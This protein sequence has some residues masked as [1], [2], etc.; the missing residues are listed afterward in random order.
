M[1]GG[2]ADQCFNCGSWSVTEIRSEGCVVCKNCG[3]VLD[4]IYDDQETIYANEDG[5]MPVHRHG[6]PINPLLPHSSM[7]TMIRFPYKL[8][9][10]QQIH[11]RMSMNYTE[12]ALYHA[13]NFISRVMEDRLHLPKSVVDIAKTMYKDMKEKRISRGLIHKALTA[14]C[15]YFA[16]KVHG[17]IKMTKQEVSVA[18]EVTTTKLNKA[19]KIF[20]DLTKDQPYFRSMFDEIEISEIVVRMTAK[21]PWR[22]EVDQWNVIKV[23]RAM[24]KLIKHYGSLDNKHINSII[25]ALVYTAT[26]ELDVRVSSPANGRP[27]KVTKS[28]VCSAYDITLITL[29]KT[30][31]EVERVVEQHRAH[32][33]TAE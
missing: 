7:S 32:L 26:S 9:R 33:E 11:D 5:T 21:L 14:A 29:N 25:A 10:L 12:R 22:Q 6:G 31:R 3:V 13:F 30:I 24:D 16:C 17:N 2:N 20:R 15:V 23:V 4:G 1:L 28:M 27:C 19:C 18:F 8:R